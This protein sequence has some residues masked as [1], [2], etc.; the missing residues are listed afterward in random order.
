MFVYGKEIIPFALVL[1][2]GYQIFVK[3]KS[4]RW[5]ISVMCHQISNY[6]EG[7]SEFD[8]IQCSFNGINIIKIQFFFILWY[9]N[10]G[11]DVC[12]ILMWIMH[13]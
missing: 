4:E 2:A 7:K 13:R 12:I 3:D 6:C 10:V 1:C 11:A 9:V 5:C 8:G